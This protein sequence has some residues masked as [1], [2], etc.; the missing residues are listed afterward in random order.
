M[1]GTIT[2]DVEARLTQNSTAVCR[3]RLTQTPTQWDTT[4][5]EWRDGT[6]TPY[7]C[8]AWRD[9]A[10]STTTSLTNGTNILT[11]GCLGAVDEPGHPPRVVH[12]HR[13]LL[14]QTRSFAVWL[15]QPF[16]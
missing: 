9:L 15:W 1:S 8:T 2:G 16:T 4:T 13:P 5:H 6:P 11:T 14:P 3:F 7:I 12:G 10:H